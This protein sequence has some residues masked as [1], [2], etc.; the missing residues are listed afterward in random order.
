VERT[1][2]ILFGFF[3]ARFQETHRSDDGVQA[4]NTLP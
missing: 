2:L 3:R 4:P 1:R